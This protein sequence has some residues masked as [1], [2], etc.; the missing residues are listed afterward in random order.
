[1]T[2][3]MPLYQVAWEEWDGD[4]A[5]AYWHVDREEAHIQ[6]EQIRARGV[7]G[8]RLTRYE[9]PLPITPSAL[10]DYLNGPLRNGKLIATWE[11]TREEEAEA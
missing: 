6:Y 3:T 8:V 10:P 7:Y 9:I 2:E 1:M 4:D 5:H 11:F